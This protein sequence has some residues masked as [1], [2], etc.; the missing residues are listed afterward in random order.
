[1]QPFIKMPK[2]DKANPDGAAGGAPPAAPVV[3]P[4]QQPPAAGATPP[5]EGGD[6]HDELGYEKTPEAKP[7]EKE[8]A[9]PKAGDPAPKAPAP[10]P[11]EIKDPATGYGKEP[12]VVPD[13]PPA[14]PA[15]VVPPATPDELDKAV[16]GLPEL[17]AKEIKAF[18]KENGV[19]PEVAKKWAD[20]VKATIAA[21][22]V[23]A[24]NMQK[25]AEQEKLRTRAAWHK[26]L[27]D[28]KDFGGE[29]FDLSLSRSEK[30]L[31]E[32]FPEL[33]KELTETGQVLR[34]S[35]M[36][37]LNR[38]AERMHATEKLTQGDP[39]VPPKKTEEK[40]AALEFYE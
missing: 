7:P 15:A 26:D 35:V 27:K 9:P 21:D 20:K 23:N 14:P 11:E 1:M 32:F 38:I 37:G 12:P 33:K 40:D 17:D 28:D 30:T 6:T 13:A 18:A 22:A 4:A 16:E 3:P 29:K 8:G 19:T 39:V 25:Q 34:P 10:K 2:L 31:S 36:R 5:A 24:T